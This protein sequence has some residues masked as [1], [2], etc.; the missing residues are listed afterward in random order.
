M[1]ST[2]LA[3]I[4]STIVG[5]CVSGEEDL[6]RQT[7]SCHPY[8]S[9]EQIRP[10]GPTQES[11]E[12]FQ[13]WASQKIGVSLWKSADSVQWLSHQASGIDNRVIPLE[14]RTLNKKE[15]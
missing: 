14:I 5:A 12:G 10:P 6:G 13:R 4:P 11:L 7:V 9:K 1:S 8:T 2:K 3:G 15:I